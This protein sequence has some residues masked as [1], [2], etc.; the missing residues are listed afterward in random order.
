MCCNSCF[1][2]WKGCSNDSSEWSSEGTGAMLSAVVVVVGTVVVS[3]KIDAMKVL[4]AVVIH[5]DSAREAKSSSSSSSS[6]PSDN[7]P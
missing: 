1:D 7:A 4:V 2:S 5:I 6:S 3:A